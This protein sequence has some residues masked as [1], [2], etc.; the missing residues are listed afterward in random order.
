LARPGRRASPADDPLIVEAA[1]FRRRLAR[2]RTEKQLARLQAAMPDLFAAH[3]IYQTGGWP[4]AVLEA[5][6]LTR[7]PLADVASRSGLI[8]TV[9]A[10]YASLFFDVAERLQSQGYIT[11]VIG[12]LERVPPGLAWSELQLKRHAY[13]MGPLVLEKLNHL[14]F[15]ANGNIQ[16]TD[17]NLKT[18]AGRF[19]ACLRLAI[20]AELPDKSLAFRREIYRS[21]RDIRELDRK[22]QAQQEASTS[23]EP[24]LERLSSANCPLPASATT[25]SASIPVLSDTSNDTL[26]TV[27]ETENDQ[28]VA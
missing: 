20:L 11:R 3:S 16:S 6:L 25:N 23:I 15:D 5:R 4:K 28:K 17:V 10:L 7:I 1:R 9:V 26:Q 24:D 19:T 27:G 13:F 21:Y 14:V 22:S 12:R 8:P 18:A 2:C